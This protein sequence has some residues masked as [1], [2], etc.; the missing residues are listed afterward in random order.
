MHAL[1]S[2]ATQALCRL[3]TSWYP[4][5]PPPPETQHRF[6][7]AR[8]RTIQVYELDNN[9][10]AGHHARMRILRHRLV[11]VLTAVL[12]LASSAAGQSIDRMVPI[13]PIPRSVIEE[14]LAAA[15]IPAASAETVL[16]AYE[17]Y[18]RQADERI[19][20]A[21][22]AVRDAGFDELQALFREHHEGR[23]FNPITGE[24]GL[25]NDP[26]QRRQR[27]EVAHGIAVSTIPALNGHRRA[28]R[29]LIE[30]M[31]RI[32]SECAV[33]FPRPRWT[34]LSS[35]ELPS[36]HNPLNPK[37][38]DMVALAWDSW[39][40][41]ALGACGA[42]LSPD[43]AARLRVQVTL[44]LT[45]WCMKGE[46]ALTRTHLA[47]RSA[48]NAF[49]RPGSV[50][51]DEVFE[52]TGAL[53][54]ERFRG[55]ADAVSRIAALVMDAAGDEHALQWEDEYRAMVCAPIFVAFWPHQLGAW[56]RAQTDA[57]A[58]EIKHA[59]ALEVRY[60]DEHAPLRD[61]AFRRI[62]AAAEVSGSATFAP[63]ESIAHERC[64]E[65]LLRLHLH[66]RD[67]MI[68]FASSLSPERQERVR[69]EWLGLRRGIAGPLPDPSRLSPELREALFDWPSMPS[70]W[71]W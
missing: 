71:G 35:L 39:E 69:R 63:R 29:E 45:D 15:A 23:A 36:S 59:E 64:N 55:N 26:E 46:I 54:R 49:P 14:Y 67:T 32:A 24:G 8:K 52:R 22:I 11:G 68:R 3:V 33:T 28:M 16:R 25:G 30:S 9:A 70:T 19:A 7:K 62:V 40:R 5:V 6:S 1:N 48:S 53:W 51:M 44:V 50:N 10:W 31:E 58:E 17:E 21:R 60:R 65:A 12:G 18:R 61:A 66:G 37:L 4:L 13:H 2:R 56:M 42:T 41:G 57:T 20:E 38:V 47:P 34:V 43:E 27:Q